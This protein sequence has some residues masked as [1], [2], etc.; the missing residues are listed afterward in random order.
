VF[1]CLVRSE[2][3]RL[4][5]SDESFKREGSLEHDSGLTLISVDHRYRIKTSDR[6]SPRRG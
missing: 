5:V 1:R 2:S 3:R 6:N 4:I